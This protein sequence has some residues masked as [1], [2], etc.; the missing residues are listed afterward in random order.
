ML[1]LALASFLII[2]MGTYCNCMNTVTLYFSITQHKWNKAIGAVADP[3][4]GGGG[5]V[6]GVRIP[7]PPSFGGPPNVI[8]WEKNV[9][10]KRANTPRFSI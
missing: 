5:G 2:V 3:A 8:Q 9:A 4:G 10:S 6:L 1:A 7:P